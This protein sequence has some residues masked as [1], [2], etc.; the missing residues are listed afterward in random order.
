[1]LKDT[2]VSSLITEGYSFANALG[3]IHLSDIYKD[4][5]EAFRNI[6]DR[7]HL[8]YVIN[9]TVSRVY[10]TNLISI[11]W[12][13][14]CA[15]RSLPIYINR[16]PDDNRPQVALTAV[17]NWLLR[18]LAT[19][20]D[21]NIFGDLYEN[22]WLAH[23]NLDNNDDN[24]VVDQAASTAA[25]SAA[26]AT[27]AL[28]I[29]LVI[30]VEDMLMTPASLAFSAASVAVSSAINFAYDNVIR[31]HGNITTAQ[32]KGKEAEE[33]EIYWQKRRLNYIVNEESIVPMN[34]LLLP[35]ELKQDIFDKY[36]VGPRF[37]KRSLK[38]QK[39]K[40]P[41]KLSKKLLRFNK[42]RHKI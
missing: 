29:T 28:F 34:Q 15:K 16:R 12:A 33:K 8:C 14:E 20:E 31:A 23:L 42:L 27:Q 38:K 36:L 11:K 1:M 21:P 25:L 22:A 26:F 13:Y 30:P 5:Y 39:L 3:D 18:G 2:L 7:R 24:M 37:G 32:L 10:D 40:K 9:N 4:P 17:H 41:R 35:K 19:N 6:N